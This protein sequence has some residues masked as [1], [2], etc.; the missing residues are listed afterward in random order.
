M[1][2]IL[3]VEDDESLGPQLLDFLEMDGFEVKHVTDSASAKALLQNTHFDMILADW[4]LPNETGIEFVRRI[5][6]NGNSVPII[7]ITGKKQILDKQAGYEAGVDDYL[8]KPFDPA[9]LSMRIRALLRRTVP[10]AHNAAN[11]QEALPLEESSIAGYEIL[12]SIGGGTSG[13][14]YKARHRLL[15]R[16]VAIKTVQNHLASDASQMGRFWLEAKAISMLSHQHITALH[17]FGLTDSGMPFLIMDYL[18]GKTIRSIIKD[19]GPFPVARALPLFDQMCDALSYVHGNGMLHRDIK[20]AN[21]VVVGQ[22]DQERLKL[23]DFGLVKLLPGTESTDLN[24]TQEGETFGTPLY[25][26]PEQC[27]GLDLDRRSDIYSLGCSMY[28]MLVG[29]PPFTGKSALQTMFL[30][31]TTET[32]RFKDIR[33]DL[34]IPEQLESVVLR[35]MARE[36]KA[37]YR[38]AHEVRSALR[39]PNEPPEGV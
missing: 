35:C 7:L 39:S 10:P 5:R 2:T 24:L 9:E 26:S 29:V 37:R 13:V 21:L 32:K 19:E 18:E 1:S 28:E 4:G 27:A 12:G 33:P 3:L 30:R 17:D 16:V 22:G 38:S 23:V 15:G 8:A 6:Q 31:V 36:L 34:K 11:R 20:P 14:V 25:M